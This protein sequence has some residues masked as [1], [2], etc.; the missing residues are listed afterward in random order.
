MKLR[1]V[2][3]LLILLMLG[4]YLIA[5]AVSQAQGPPAPPPPV[6]DYFPD[7]WKDFLSTEGKFKIRF[8]G[9]PKESSTER[10]SNGVKLSIHSINYKSFIMYGV[11]YTDYPQNIDNP[12]TVKMFFDTVRDSGLKGIAYTNPKLVK[13]SDGSINGYP[14][15]F[16]RIDMGGEAVL[17]IKYVAIQNRLFIIGVTTPKGD[18]IGL[19]AENDYEKIAMSFLDSFQLID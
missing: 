7:R 16:L 10:V 18:K 11:M 4:F 15:R 17:R 2:N 3:L 1:I 6:N 5:P 12:S 19:G 8:P 9:I 13:E 14:S